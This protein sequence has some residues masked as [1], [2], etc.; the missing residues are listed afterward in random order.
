[1]IARRRLLVAFGAATLAGP[2]PSLA[3]PPPKIRRIGCLATRARS[4]PSN[5]ELFEISFPQGM[6]EL[7]YFEG[8]NLA[9]EWRFAEGKY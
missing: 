1:M 6:R 9:T 7:G 3:Q 4:T 8:R 5:P 2:F